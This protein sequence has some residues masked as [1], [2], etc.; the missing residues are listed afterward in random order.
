MF[1]STW[2]ISDGDW[3]DNRKLVI[4]VIRKGCGVGMGIRMG[5]EKVG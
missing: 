5:T 2:Y 3:G 4:W 1:I